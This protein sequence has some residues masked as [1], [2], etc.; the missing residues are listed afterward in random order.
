M[1]SSRP[2]VVEVGYAIFCA[3]NSLHNV[4]AAVTEAERLADRAESKRWEI[5]NGSDGLHDWKSGGKHGK[6]VGKGRFRSIDPSLRD[7]NSIY[8][9]LLPPTSPPTNSVLLK[10]SFFS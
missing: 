7:V 3:I 1:S 6:Q 9:H 2:L 10:R 5:R 4:K 8:C